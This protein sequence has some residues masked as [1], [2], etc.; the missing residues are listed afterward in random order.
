MAPSLEL[1]PSLHTGEQHTSSLE[2]A[3]SDHGIA[4]LG[5]PAGQVDLARGIAAWRQSEVGAD[6]PG[7]SEAAWLI[8]SGA[9]GQGINR[10][11]PRHGHETTALI[12]VPRHGQQLAGEASDLPAHNLVHGKQG[13]NSLLQKAMPANQLFSSEAEDMTTRLCNDETMILE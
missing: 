1:A 8:D 11:D 7:A 13:P 6:T 4:A 9:E 12:I 2:E 3:G 10:A 5:D